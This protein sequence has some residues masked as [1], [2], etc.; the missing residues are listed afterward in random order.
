[1]ANPYE[2]AIVGTKE[3]LV[4]SINEAQVLNSAN[5][6]EKKAVFAEVKPIATAVGQL[7]GVR[8]DGLV[9]RLD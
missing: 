2:G 8:K 3:E 6:Y 4:K 5:W 1:L 7:Q 9:G